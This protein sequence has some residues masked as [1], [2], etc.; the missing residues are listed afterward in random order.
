LFFGSCHD[1]GTADVA[2]PTRDNMPR[3]D[4]GRKGATDGRKESVNDGVGTR[5]PV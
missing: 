5:G 1:D 2:A 3:T 4:E